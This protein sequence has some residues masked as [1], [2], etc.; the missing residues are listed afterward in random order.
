MRH[1]PL[2]ACMVNKSDIGHPSSMHVLQLKSSHLMD[3]V[4]T[5]K[6]KEKI[7]KHVSLSQLIILWHE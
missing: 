6:R 7:I 3:Q 1:P 4:E 2:H 5:R